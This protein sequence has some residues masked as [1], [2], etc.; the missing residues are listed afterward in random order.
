[1]SPYS[2]FK[3]MVANRGEIALRILRSCR[4]LGM[5][6]VAVYSEVDEQ[7]LHARYAD[8]AVCI[9]PAD[10][11]SSYLNMSTIIDAA[12]KT[13]VRAIHPG[14][15][16]LA[17]NPDFAQAVENAG[18][19]FIGP[20]PETVALTGDKL[21]AR[22]MAREAGLPV[23]PGPDE[24]L[25]HGPIEPTLSS[26]VVFPVLIKAVAGGGGRGIR[27]ANDSAELDL[28][29]AAARKEAMAAFGN[30]DVYLEPLVQGARHIEVQIIG[31][32]EGNVLCLGERECSIQRRRQK[33]IEE[34][35]APRLPE[36]L[37]KAFHANAV[38]LVEQLKYRGLGTVE[39][40][41]DKNGEYY[42]I[43]INPRIQVEHPVTEMVTGIDLVR[44]QLI[45][46]ASGK[47]NLSAFDILPRGAAIEARILAEDG[48]QGFL[49]ATG[50]ITHLLL[51]GG[52]G[53]RVDSG[54]YL[55]MPVTADYDSLLA[56][57][58]VWDENR[59]RAVARMKR[60]LIEFQVGGVPTDLDFLQ[61]IVNSSSFKSGRTDT[62]YLDHF[63]PPQNVENESIEQDLAVAIAILANQETK[64]AEVSSNC[65]ETT[66]NWKYSAWREQMRG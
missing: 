60:A 26:Q 64:H 23:L 6:S 48:S 25:M 35:P 55:G 34:A 62:T 3:V 8:E 57:V 47:L 14:Y 9:G 58:I 27:L 20:R 2:S 19:I 54:L 45:L 15:G 49:P 66:A 5:P 21:A 29:I 31:D 65:V 36:P 16:F 1:M 53:V 33:L 13:G 10:A 59:T 24:P 41:L 39:F 42:F 11:A 7:A 52:Q 18:L 63:T 32:G 37:R 28:M 56:K 51:P 50:E 46:A 44:E 22:R 4:E 12:L 38:K 30:D 17:E 40:L 43:E 61:Q